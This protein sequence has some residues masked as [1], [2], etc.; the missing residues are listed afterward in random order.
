VLMDV[1]ENVKPKPHLLFVWWATRSYLWAALSPA[2]VGLL[3]PDGDNDPI[4][5]DAERITMN[6]LHH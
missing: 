5:D 6:E 4:C 1:L 3:R 2:V